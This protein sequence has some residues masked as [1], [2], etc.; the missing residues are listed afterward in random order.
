MLWHE[1]EHLGD[2]FAQRPQRP[3]TGW[4]AAGTCHGLVDVRLAGQVIGQ[5]LAGRLGSGRLG[6]HRSR[7]HGGCRGVG[8]QLLETELELRDL[9]IEL[10]AG[11]T[12]LHPPEARELELQVLDQHIALPKPRAHRLQSTLGGAQERLQALHIVR[13]GGCARHKAL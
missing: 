1:L 12:E 10:L 13:Q 8:F 11:A 5:G 7:G 3:A 2:I 4:T 9:G 6:A